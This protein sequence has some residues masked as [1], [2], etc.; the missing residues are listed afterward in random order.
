MFVSYQQV[1]YVAPPAIFIANPPPLLRT[2]RLLHSVTVF[3]N[4]SQSS[5]A[6]PAAHISEPPATATQLSKP[7][8]AMPSSPRSG[9]SARTEPMATPPQAA[10][11]AVIAKAATVTNRVDKN[12]VMISEGSVN[13][14][15]GG[16]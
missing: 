1:P 13:N 3:E 14:C 16:A 8:T 5:M 4:D 12:F 6:A 9:S 2:G 11:I 15:D 7:N 10:V